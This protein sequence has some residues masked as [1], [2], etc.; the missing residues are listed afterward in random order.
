MTVWHT[1]ERMKD[2]DKAFLLRFLLRQQDIEESFNKG[3]SYNERENAVFDGA[4]DPW[5]A[6]LFWQVF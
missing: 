5:Q 1:E 3:T 2:I 6:E 4:G